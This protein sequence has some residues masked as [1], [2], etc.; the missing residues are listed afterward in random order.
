MVILL[1]NVEN[2]LEIVLMR[3]SNSNVTFAA[4][5]KSFHPNLRKNCTVNEQYIVLFKYVHCK[6]TLSNG[7]SDSAILYILLCKISVTSIELSRQH[8]QV[9]TCLA[10]R[11]A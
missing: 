7:K 9:L 6:L 3:R 1:S 2:K 5:S 11:A 10:Q 8:H 4:Q